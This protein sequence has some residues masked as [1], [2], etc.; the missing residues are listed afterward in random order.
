[1][2]LWWNNKTIETFRTR[3]ECMIEQYSKY[4]IPGFGNVSMA[5]VPSGAQL[6]SFTRVNFLKASTV[7]TDCHDKGI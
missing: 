1:M 5:R 4:S 2:Q 6:C 7:L 3:A